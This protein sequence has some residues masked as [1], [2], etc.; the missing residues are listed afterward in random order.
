MQAFKL[1]LVPVDADVNR[2]VAGDTQGKHG[3]RDK[4]RQAG[5]EG[6]LR[7]ANREVN[8]TV[9][10]RLSVIEAPD[11]LRSR[12]LNCT[13]ETASELT[14]DVF[15]RRLKTLRYGLLPCL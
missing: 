9:F 13:A 14:V 12:S 15:M 11:R 2:A 10:S 7:V 8:L 6:S 1:Q 4:A 5:Y 3:L